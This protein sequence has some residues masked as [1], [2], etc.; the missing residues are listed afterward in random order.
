MGV[1]PRTGSPAP[2]CPHVTGH[3]LVR[4]EGNASE[5]SKASAH[6]EAGATEMRCFVNV[7]GLALVQLR[8]GVSEEEA[9]ELPH[10]PGCQICLTR[11]YPPHCGRPERPPF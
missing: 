8:R 2:D 3:L 1:R 4:F 7:E 11:L 5:N 9:L 10:A 6:G